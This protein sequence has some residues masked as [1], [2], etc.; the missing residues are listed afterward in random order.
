M[1]TAVPKVEW[2][3]HVVRDSRRHA[4]SAPRNSV[5]LSNAHV[6]LGIDALSI[7]WYYHIT[8]SSDHLDH[9][10]PTRTN[11]TSELELKASRHMCHLDAG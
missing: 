6:G 4:R 2:S 8:I 1:P 5:R 9:Q 7:M 3:R 10:Q 11:S